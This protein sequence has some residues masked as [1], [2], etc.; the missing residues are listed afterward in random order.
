[1]SQWTVVKDFRFLTDGPPGCMRV[2]MLRKL[3]IWRK[4][5][6]LNG[7]RSKPFKA[8]VFVPGKTNP[9]PVHNLLSRSRILHIMVG[10]SLKGFLC[11]PPNFKLQP[12]FPLHPFPLMTREPILC[13]V[14]PAISRTS[15]WRLARNLGRCVPV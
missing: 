15:L 12:P 11:P 9:C 4:H 8:V 13:A 7:G 3:Q 6:T 10:P 14:K 5:L 2:L 1:M